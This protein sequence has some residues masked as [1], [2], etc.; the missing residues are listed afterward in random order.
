MRS[1][2][3]IALLT[4]CSL[5]IASCDKPRIETPKPPASKLVC[6]PLPARPALPAEYKIDWSKV[7]TVDEAR[8][9]HERFVA[10]LRDRE[11]R[12]AGYIVSIE[13]AW[14]SCSSNLSFVRTF[15]EALP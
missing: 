2:L 8:A 4:A 12:V 14:F 9:E 3:A 13:G 5:A 7:N 15:T 11:G 6:E 10:T 1:A